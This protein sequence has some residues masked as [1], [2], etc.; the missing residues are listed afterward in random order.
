MGTSSMG[1]S[2]IEEYYTE[3][4]FDYKLLWAL[5][6]SHGLHAGYHDGRD[7]SHAEAIENMNRE[8]AERAGI[9]PDDHVLDCGCGVGG[10]SVWLATERGAT[11]TGVDIVP[12]QLRE[13]RKLA[14]EEGVEDRATFTR[15]DFTDLP[16]ADDSVDVVW[17]IEAICHAEDKAEFVAEA[18]RVLRPDGRLIVADGF[19]AVDAMTPG[20][21]ESMNVWLDGWA[22]PNLATLAGFGAALSEAGF[23]AVET[24]DETEQVLPSS[25]RLYWASRLLQPFGRVASA[26]GLRNETQAD[27]RRAARYQ[28]ETLTDGLWQYG[29]VSAKR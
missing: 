14:A 28:H 2:R 15:G 11:V 23:E 8:L 26:V 9:G 13:A 27:N 19:R 20:E 10:S 6:D 12:L 29:I 7:Q 24:V 16:L 5:E 3:S 4:H 22:V 25:R 21:R 1:V 18:A 17:G